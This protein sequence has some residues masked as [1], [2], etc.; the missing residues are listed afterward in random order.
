MYVIGLAQRSKTKAYQ[1]KF[2]NM[3]VFDSSIAT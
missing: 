1:D 2:P 3:S